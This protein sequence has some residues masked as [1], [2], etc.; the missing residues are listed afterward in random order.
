VEAL[1][2]CDYV[3]L[4]NLPSMFVKEYRQA[5]HT[6]KFLGCSNQLA[7]WG[8]MED[9]KL[10]DEVDGSLFLVDTEWWSEEG[11][12]PDFVNQLV[13]E[14]HPGSAEE[15]I[16]AGKSY[17]ATINAVLIME[18]I[19]S[20]AE[21]VGHENLDSQ[22]IYEAAQSFTLTFDGLQRHSY[23]ETKRASLDRIAVYEVSESEENIVRISDWIPIETAP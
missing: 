5:G 10:W 3:W 8:L 20:A 6:A 13:R 9:M 12:L 17:F 4:P 23:S 22:A 11:E 7:F 16:R 1:K 19:K 15:I 14:K 2:D 18:I 21:A